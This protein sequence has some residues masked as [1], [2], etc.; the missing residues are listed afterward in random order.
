MKNIRGAKIFCA[1]ILQQKGFIYIKPFN[2][3]YY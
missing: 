1:P 2:N 3:N